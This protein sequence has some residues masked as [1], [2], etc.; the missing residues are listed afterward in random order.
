MFRSLRLV[1]FLSFAALAAVSTAC[2]DTG[3]TGDDTNIDAPLGP[4]SAQG[5]LTIQEIHADAMVP[6]TPVELKGKVVVAIDNF[7]SRKGN[8]WVAEEGGGEFSGVLVFGAPVEQVALLAVGDK[9]DI[10][11]AEKSEFALAADTSGRTTTELV[12]VSGGAMTVTKVGTG[13]VPA[14][15]VIDAAI[16]TNMD[17]AT[18]YAEYEKWEGV[19]TR[20]EN[21]SVVGG[22]AQIGGTMPDPT[23]REFV[24]TGA[25]HVDSSLANIPSVNDGGGAT[26]LVHTGDC[27]ASVTGMGDYF[28]S[29]KILPRATNDIA[30]N[31]TGCPAPQS[32]PI[33]D[34]QSGTIT[35]GTVVNLDNVVVTAIA[36]NKKN[37]WVS[38]AAQA[39]PN[40]SIYV[41]RGSGAAVLPA[42]IVIG[43]HVNVSGTVAEFNGNDGGDTLTQIANNPS[44]TLNPAAATA[45]LPL[46]G[47]SVATLSG[48]QAE[49]YESVLV[50]LTNIRLTGA[51]P[52]A[53]PYQRAMTDGTTTFI[54]DD[55][56]IRQQDAVGTCFSSIVGVWQYNPFMDTNN[57]VFIPRDQ[58]GDAVVGT[59][60]L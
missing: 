29:Y 53:Q 1:S 33:T 60:C 39:A 34:I 8:F 17:E 36:F 15:H 12:P 42:E 46:E 32:P 51:V 38:D 49:Q 7:G 6:G 5:G 10:T 43:A 50:K 28:F 52:A 19:L 57:W 41:F 2:R 58:A 48:A 16:L 56:I 45:P 21:V 20:V 54:S 40:N 24:V 44:V 9:V 23:F 31:G 14:P 3:G 55:D 22:I 37:L 18:R 59:G 30:L 11:G 25:L 27:L 47:V 13:T 35:A 26:D 4:D